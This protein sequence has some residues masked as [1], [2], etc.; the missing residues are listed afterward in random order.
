[1]FER[2]IRQL[3]VPEVSK[4]GQSLLN[5][6][7]I[8]VVG[9]GGLGCS[10]LQF[11]IGAGCCNITICDKD[12]INQTNL[13]RQTLYNETNIGLKKVE[14][15]KSILSKL[16]S[17]CK[18]TIVD[19]NIKSENAFEII[20]GHSVII[21]CGDSFS[22][23]YIL[24]DECYKL[25]KPF[26]TSSAIRFE[27]YVGGF[28][29]GGP[30]LRAVFP[31]LPDNIEN[32]NTAGI[33]GP[34]VGVLGSMQSQMVINYILNLSPNPIGQMISINLKNYQFSSFRFDNAS[35]P[36]KSNFKFI[37]LN[38]IQKD[39]IVIE[40]RDDKEMPVNRTNNIIRI[41]IA[42]IEKRI[43]EFDKNK[44]LIFMCRSGVR[45]WK[46][47]KSIED[48]WNNKISLIADNEIISSYGK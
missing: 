22:L 13:H 4:N 18:I 30:S 24:S 26:F 1:M 25:K 10:A 15:A 19:D 31:D 14:V 34:V 2:Y 46:A 41:P 11:L 9:A 45:A 43:S 38:Q 42:N 44:H 36:K 37:S 8:L 32:C 3:T 16:N 47:A 6:T 23:S 40:L 7:K 29:G 35:E 20:E 48:K 12:L 33:L 5:D 39:D 28:C 17:N 27:G 21:D